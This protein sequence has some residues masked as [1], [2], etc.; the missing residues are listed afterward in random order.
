MG[1]TVVEICCGSVDDVLE[2][3]RAGAHRVELNSSLFLGG[4]T[5]TIGALMEAKRLAPGMQ[6]MTMVRPRAGGFCYTQ[7]DYRTALVDAR[8][9]LGHG[10]DG[11]VF[12]FL[13]SDG[14]VDT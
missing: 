14:T 12:G 2:A 9:L 8:E 13:R 5:P 3:Q 7:A 11:I 4:L 1:N 6:V 10:A